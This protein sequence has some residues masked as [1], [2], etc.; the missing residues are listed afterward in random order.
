M[1]KFRVTKRLVWFISG[2]ETRIAPEIF[3]ES[4]GT[5]VTE[6][7]GILTFS[8]R[9]EKEW[10]SLMVNV[11][12][13]F[14]INLLCDFCFKVLKQKQKKIWLFQFKYCFWIIYLAR[15]RDVRPNRFCA[16]KWVFF[17]KNDVQTYSYLHENYFYFAPDIWNIVTNPINAF[18]TNFLFFIKSYVNTISDLNNRCTNYWFHFY[19]I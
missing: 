16:R 5:G 13:I 7:N 19:L 11:V 18:S 3:G 6:I 9:D 10:G 4:G 12:L 17:D 15:P 1:M 2:L 14:A 8:L